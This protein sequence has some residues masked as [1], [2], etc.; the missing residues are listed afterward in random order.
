MEEHKGQE[1]NT[2]IFSDEVCEDKNQQCS[3]W[4][5]SGECSKNPAYML[6]NCA[7]SCGECGSGKNLKYFKGCFQIFELQNVLEF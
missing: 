1:A 4:A 7:K 2:S 6:P 3:S 5:E